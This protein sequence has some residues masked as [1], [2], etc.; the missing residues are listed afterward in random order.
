MSDER[1]L[2][3]DRLGLLEERPKPPGDHLGDAPIERFML[4]VR[5]LLECVTHRLRNRVASDFSPSLGNPR[6]PPDGVPPTTFVAVGELLL[7]QPTD[8]VANCVAH[9]TG[10][11]LDDILV[12]RTKRLEPNAHRS[13]I[14]IEL[15]ADP[16][17]S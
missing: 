13:R 14:E 6:P 10:L 3:L 12:Q 9:R 11:D 15:H 5:S 1:V 4:T 7:I 8:H 16:V 17:E 2:E